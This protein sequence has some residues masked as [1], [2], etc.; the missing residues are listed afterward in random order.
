MDS[1]AAPGILTPDEMLGV[2]MDV[3][4]TQVAPPRTKGLGGEQIR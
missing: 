4:A 3:A 2:S 1:L